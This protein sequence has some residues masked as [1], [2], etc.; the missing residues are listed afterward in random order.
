MACFSA[1]LPFDLH[2]AGRWFIALRDI[3]FI[4]GEMWEGNVLN[5]RKSKIIK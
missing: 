1:F 4:V 2:F 5:N 3:D